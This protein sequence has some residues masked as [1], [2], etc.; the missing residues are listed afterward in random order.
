MT[1]KHFLLLQGVAT[2]FFNELGKAIERNGHQVTKL[3][4][5]GGDLLFSRDLQTINVNI[6]PS[7]LVQWSQRF[8]EKNNIT[9]V[10]LFGDTRPVHQPILRVMKNANITVHVYEEGYIRP[11]WVTLEKNGVNGFSSY[12]HLTLEQWQEQSLKLPSN[13]PPKKISSNMT[14]RAFYDLTYRI[15]NGIFFTR[16]LH[17]Q[18]HRPL[19]GLWEYLGWI[20]RFSSHKLWRTKQDKKTIQQVLKEKANF[21]LLPL[22]LESDAQ[23]HTHSPFKKVAEVIYT[24][25]ESFAK[26]A[27]SDSVLVIK[28]HPLSTGIPNHEKTV[29]SL[30]KQFSLTTRIIFLETGDLTPL[31]RKTRGTVLVNSTTATQAIQLGSPTMAL[32]KALFNLPGLT[33]QG[34]LDQFWTQ[35]TPPDQQLYLSY[36]HVLIQNTQINGDFYSPEGIAMTIRNS[37]EK[38]EALPVPI[39]ANKQNILITG[40]SKGIGEAL[41]YH[42]ASRETRL[43]L[44]A[45]DSDK[46]D[47]VSK[48]CCHLGAEVITKVLDV[49]HG[50]QLADWIG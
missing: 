29:R 45:R 19:T 40:A 12:T 3:N 39:T 1:V 44:V 10:I 9:D 35:S 25:V 2:P 7:E 46:L 42:Y 23:I 49:S 33:F 13:L 22:Q 20:K 15:A 41:A 8:I 47:E 4:F 16:F 17:Y 28:N 38:L 30:A 34:S 24:V 37:L 27:P 11:H 14:S 36:R 32:G 5:C 31:L 6:D 43:I 50:E 21:Y 48:K 26:H 18:T